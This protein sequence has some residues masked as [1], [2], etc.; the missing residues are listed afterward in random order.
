LSS[1]TTQED[2]VQAATSVL[3]DT[4]KTPSGNDLLPFLARARAGDK[5]DTQGRE[6]VPGAF[7][8]THP[9]AVGKEH[10]RSYSW[11]EGVQY[12]YGIKLF[13]LPLASFIAKPGVGQQIT[14]GTPTDP[15]KSVKWSGVIPFASDS[16]LGREPT[17]EECRGFMTRMSADFGIE[18]QDGAQFIEDNGC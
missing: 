4:L 16:Y 11:A 12:N 7:V 13:L 17:H 18:R 5:R 8:G 15:T 14:G 3:Q 1:E 6:P 2:Q 9:E 10:S